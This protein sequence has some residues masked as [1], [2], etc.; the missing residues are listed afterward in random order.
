MPLFTVNVRHTH[1]IGPNLI[2]L[3]S[4]LVS[5]AEQAKAALDDPKATVIAEATQVNAKLA[6]LEAK[7]QNSVDPAVADELLADIAGIK[8]TVMGII[9]DEPPVEQPPAEGV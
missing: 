8:S 7:I 3:G 1:D 6:D 9:P 5:F 4:R 2:S